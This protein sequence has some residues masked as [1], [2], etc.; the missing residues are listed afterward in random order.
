[1]PEEI[2]AAFA[3]IGKIQAEA[4]VLFT[5]PMIFS[6]RRRIAELAAAIRLPVMSMVRGHAEAGDLMAYGPNFFDMYRRA[7]DYVD[8]IFK[9]ATPADLPFEQPTKFELVI[10]VK[11]AETLGI[12]IPTTLLTRADELIE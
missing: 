6:E 8:K 1:V 7:A 11:T 10:N 5:E 4:L 12:T 2:A 3:Q 9:G